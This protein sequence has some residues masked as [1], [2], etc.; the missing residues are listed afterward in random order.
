MLILICLCT[1]SSTFACDSLESRFD[2]C[3]GTTRP[4][5]LTLQEKD[6]GVF[7]QNGI[8]GPT[9]VAGDI[10]LNVSKKVNK[11]NYYTN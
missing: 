3:Y 11:V 6:T 4:T 5:G 9:S 7:L 10:F 2:T 1:H 8:G